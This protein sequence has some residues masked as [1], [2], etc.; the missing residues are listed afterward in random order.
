MRLLRLCLLI[1]A[2][3]LFLSD[4]IIVYDSFVVS[5]TGELSRRQNVSSCKRAQAAACWGFPNLTGQYVTPKLQKSQAERVFR[6][7]K[8]TKVTESPTG[9]PGKSSRQLKISS[10]N[11]SPRQWCDCSSFPGAAKSSGNGDDADNPDN[12]G[13]PAQR[14][15]G[16]AAGNPRYTPEYREHPSELA[17]SADHWSAPQPFS[18]RDA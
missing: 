9:S 18:L 5:L 7:K 12:S 6:T 1:L 3:R 10:L 11:Q 4:P 17:A 16:A 13:L 8:F 2:L 15:H 14:R